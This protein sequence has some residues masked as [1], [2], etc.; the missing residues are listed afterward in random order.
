MMSK[1]VKELKKSIKTRTAKIAKHE[2][3]LKA[4]KK[5]LKKAA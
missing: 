4:L 2:T 1:K 5:K 3:K